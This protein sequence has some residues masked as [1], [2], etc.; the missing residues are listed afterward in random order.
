MKALTLAALC[1]FVSTGCGR[2]QA[3]ISIT[4]RRVVATPP[5]PAVVDATP[6]Q[7]FGYGR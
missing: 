2:S 6:A 3:A 7:R 5:R 4:D 1:L